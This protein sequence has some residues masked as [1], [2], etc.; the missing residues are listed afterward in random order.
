MFVEKF[1]IS[2]WVEQRSKCKLVDCSLSKCRKMH[3]QLLHCWMLKIKFGKCWESL[4]RWMNIEGFFFPLII[5]ESLH[6]LENGDAYWSTEAVLWMT[7]AVVVLVVSRILAS[8]MLLHCSW[9]LLMCL[10]CGS[11]F[12]YWLGIWTL[13]IS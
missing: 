10:L 2:R 7:L 11:S 6:L 8:Q 9:L 4:E 3:F 5:E 12:H 1:F 13:R